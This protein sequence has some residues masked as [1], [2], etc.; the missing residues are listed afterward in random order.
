MNIDHF[1]EFIYLAE[2][3]SFTKTAKRFYTSRSVISRHVTALER[4]LGVKLLE[5]DRH[6]VSVTKEGEVFCREARVL[7]DDFERLLLC[8]RLAAEG[9]EQVVRIGYLR[10]AARPF[11]VQFA[12]SMK[13]NHP[14]IKP[15]FTCM[16]YDELFQALDDRRLDIVLSMDV[17][18]ESTA[19]YGSIFIYRDQFYAV[20]AHTN[21]LCS[22]KEGLKCAD[23]MGKRLL[24]SDSFA[25]SRLNDYLLK[26]LDSA[27]MPDQFDYC[28]DADAMRLRILVDGSIALQS[29]MNLPLP[30]DDVVMLPV[31]DA[32]LSFN[33]RAYFRKD[34]NGVVVSACDSSLAECRTHLERQPQSASLPNET[35]RS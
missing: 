26:T 4:E 10:N 8:T 31:L 25:C 23:L 21:P 13:R 2:S 24:L 7:V 27:P 17:D 12:R 18:S 19:D 14:S 15:I 22:K 11:I 5:R 3:L 9:P 33:A 30:G 16:N 1:E 32:D 34:L 28:G 35:R 29:S 20:M 6:N